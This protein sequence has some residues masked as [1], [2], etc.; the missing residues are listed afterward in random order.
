[1]Y[2]TGD[3]GRWGKDGNLEFVGRADDQVKIRGYRIEMGEIEALLTDHP[4]L[5]HAVVIAREDEETGK[6][7]VAY[8][9]GEHVGAEVL[10]AYLVSRLPEYMVPAAYVYLET[11]PLTVNGKPDRRALPAPE[12]ENYLRRRYEPPVGEIETRLARIWAEVLN[13]ERVGR[14]DNFFEL[15]GHSLLA[16]DIIERLRREGALIDVG[17]LF[18]APTLA[19]LAAVIVDTTKNIDILV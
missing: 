9:T 14:H 3:L 4:G 15:G 18:T 7:L 2:R 5:R 13:L 19:D 8:Y 6:R 16:I 1:M 17:E 11:I 12:A 10:R